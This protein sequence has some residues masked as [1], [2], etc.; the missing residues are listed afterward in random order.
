M[1]FLPAGPGVLTESVYSEIS[2]HYGGA[3]RGVNAIVV[4]CD[5]SSSL[6]PVDRR[7]LT[8]RRTDRPSANLFTPGADVPPIHGSKDAPC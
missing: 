8:V 4:R 2:S 3:W 6:L 5:G 7:S 1:A